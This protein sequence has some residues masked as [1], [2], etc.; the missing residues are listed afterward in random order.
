MEERLKDHLAGFYHLYDPEP[1][2]RGTKRMVWEG[3]WDADRKRSVNEIAENYP[4]LCE[5]IGKLAGLYRLFLASFDSEP[6]GRK[7]IEAA[8]AKHLYDQEGVVGGFQD[9]GIRYW[10]RTDAEEPVRV[11]IV[12]P[13]SVLGMPIEVMA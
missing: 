11:E 7:R 1:F 13:Q 12:C 6:R 3:H 9:K 8:I 4:H 2:Q 10:P 5:T